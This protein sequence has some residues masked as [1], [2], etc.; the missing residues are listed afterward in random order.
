[1]PAVSEKVG[2]NSAGCPVG[3]WWSIHL[4]FILE[5]TDKDPRYIADN[6]YFYHCAFI[7]GDE[8]AKFKI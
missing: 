2:N 6:D 4:N 7:N 5:L 8:F 3:E 1:M